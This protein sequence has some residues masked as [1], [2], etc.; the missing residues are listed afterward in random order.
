MTPP[1]RK[2]FTYIQTVNHPFVQRSTCPSPAGQDVEKQVRELLE[3][4]RIVPSCSSYGAPVLF[5]PKPDECF[6]MCIDYRELKLTVKDT[7]PIP[8]IDDLID[9]FE[10]G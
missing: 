5:V 10:W 7:Y 9:D 3:T 8:Q 4:G 2:V 6:R 1:R